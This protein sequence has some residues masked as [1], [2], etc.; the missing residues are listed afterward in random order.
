MAGDATVKAICRS[1]SLLSLPVLYTVASTAVPSAEYG[2][3]VKSF[4]R[5]EVEEW[6][7]L[8]LSLS[9]SRCNA[10]EGDRDRASLEGELCAYLV[11]SF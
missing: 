8:S 6:G 9:L 3:V 10:G 11:V 1:S 4:L 5:V 2:C 7:S